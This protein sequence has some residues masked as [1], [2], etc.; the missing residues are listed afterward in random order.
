M[1]ESRGFADAHLPG[2]GRPRRT[3]PLGSGLDNTAR[4]V[5]GEFVVRRRR[6]GASPPRPA[7]SPLPTPVPLAVDG[8]WTAYRL[9]PDVLPLDAGATRDLARRLVDFVALVRTW[10]LPALLAGAADAHAALGLRAPAV[11]RF[12]ATPPPPPPDELVLAHNDLGAEHVLV[13]VG[14]TITGVPDR[15]GAARC[16]RPPTSACRT[17]TSVPPPHRPSRIVVHHTATDNTHDRSE[18]HARRLAL[19][20]QREHV[21]RGWGDTGQNRESV[22]IENEGAHTDRL[23]TAP[24]WAA[25]VWLCARV[26]RSSG[27]EPTG[28][29]GHRDYRDGAVCPRRRPP[30]RAPAA[31]RARGRAARRLSAQRGSARS[32]SVVT[33]GSSA[34]SA[35]AGSTARCPSPAP[36]PAR[37][38]A[39]RSR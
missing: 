36:A 5:D 39:S 15:T 8:P 38:G 35:T 11:E 37:T 17:A 2:R 9:L 22:G 21:R 10:D 13:D 26:C 30:R 24:Q 12:P 25:L 7:R 6:D 14:T 20:F 32:G 28:I 4:L 23:P 31:A 19:F 18:A 33:S 16:A 27:I 3:V 1:P 29:D 34:P